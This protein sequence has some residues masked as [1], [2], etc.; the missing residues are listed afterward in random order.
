MKKRLFFIFVVLFTLF[1]LFSFYGFR[2]FSETYIPSNRFEENATN[3][4]RHV[5]K[6]SHEI[7]ERHI[8]QKSKYE[9]AAKYIENELLSYG[10][11]VYRQKVLLDGIEADHLIARHKRP[12]NYD[13]YIVGAHYD[14]VG[15]SPGADDNASAVAGMLELA[16]LLS[17]KEEAR[18][19]EFVAFANEEFSFLN[20]NQMGSAA[21]AGE[22]KE[23]GKD[24]EA[25]LVFE[26]IG[27]YKDDFFSQ[28]YPLLVGPFYPSKGN[29]I[30]VVGNS[31]SSELTKEIARTI[32]TNTRLPVEKISFNADYVE[33]LSFSDH[34]S[35][36][37]EGYQA[38]MITDTAFYRNPHYHQPT[39]TYDTL[40]YERMSELV[41]GIEVF[42]E[43]KI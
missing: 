1:P 20:A 31:Y 28:Q 25:V 38:V 23:K 3:L 35:F 26:M 27:Y 21:Y 43:E 40:D 22:A 7:G 19:I 42:L 32:K 41:R 9:E 33:G 36:W 17:D 37:K 18:Q 39:D 8:H 14:S 12:I 30:T 13:I 11:D 16:R 29:F 4:K 10:Y 24:V 5:Y 6:L 34:A 2:F 15:G